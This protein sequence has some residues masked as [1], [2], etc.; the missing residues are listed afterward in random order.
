MYQLR[1][2]NVLF[3]SDSSTFMLAA[4]TVSNGYN[5]TS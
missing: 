1:R 5:M 4:L 3:T 2:Y